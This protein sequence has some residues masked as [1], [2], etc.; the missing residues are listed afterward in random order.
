[1]G[2]IGAWG[3]ESQNLVRDKVI[4]TSGNG[5]AYSTIE[6]PP[7]TASQA[8]L[9]M[10]S[11]S[12]GVVVLDSSPSGSDFWIHLNV[13]WINNN[14]L[15]NNFRLGW[16]AGANTAG[17]LSRENTTGRLQIWVGGV[18]RATSA[19][20]MPVAA[21]KRLHVHVDYLNAG[22]GFVRVYED[23]QVGGTP[24]VSWT[25]NTNPSAYGAIDNLLIGDFLAHW[26]DL[27]VLDPNDGL[28]PTDIND[29]AFTTIGSR[30]PNGDGTDTAWV[31]TPGGGAD[32]EDIDEIPN[33]DANYIRASAASQASTFDFEDATFGQPLAVKM[34]VRTVRS[35]T[36][37]G[38]N[39]ALRQ[40][41]GAT[42]TDT[43]DLPCPGD[44]DVHVILHTDANGA[45]WS[46]T[47]FDNSEFGVVS[48]T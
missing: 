22:T 16:N 4:Q 40:R 24:I 30:E 37:A 12:A 9:S 21:W 8:S 1:M 15:N 3:F 33:D 23:G 43:A 6:L 38:A 14:T 28:T 45:D 27:M 10:P 36:A 18:L 26:D 7:L 41:L 29:I 25:G 39:I 34:K 42:V 31:A 35:G 46:T 19:V 5:M 17:Y 48:K 2:I 13:R 11:I 20:A 32:Y 44:G 47:S